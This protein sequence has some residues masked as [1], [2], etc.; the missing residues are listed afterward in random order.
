MLVDG[1]QLRAVWR[2]VVPKDGARYTLASVQDPWFL[3][4]S[5]DGWPA[6]LRKLTNR[7]AESTRT[8]G[9]IRLRLI[10]NADLQVSDRIENAH[11]AVL[12]CVDPQLLETF[13]VLA[14]DVMRTVGNEPATSR[15]ILERL[16]QW[17]E[18]LTNASPL[19]DT[20]QLGLWGEL[21]LLARFPNLQAA[22]DGW[23][24]PNRE[25]LDFS[26]NA[27]GI[28]VKTSTQRRRHLL[29]WQQA[30]F[31]ASQVDVYLVSLHVIPDPTG[32]SLTQQV[33]KVLSR[34]HDPYALREKLIAAKYHDAGS[35][36]GRWTLTE[37]PACFPMS[38]VPRF[39]EVPIGVLDVKWRVDLGGKKPLS[40]TAFDKLLQ[41]FAG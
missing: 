20:E 7:P 24:G 4:C 36:D 33:T 5:S 39:S 9:A 31:A 14:M 30:V 11:L 18:L 21:E 40:R 23:H 6:L 38:V 22:I 13:V 2:D 32:T 29:R 28:E 37:E 1:A 16:G 3:G 8:V 41:M 19:S 26:R 12:E 27:I 10:S 15:Q 35:Y 25:A 34:A 17:R